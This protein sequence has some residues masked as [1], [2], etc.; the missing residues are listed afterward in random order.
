MDDLEYSEF[1][2]YPCRACGSIEYRY[3]GGGYNCREGHRNEE[4][5]DQV[6]DEDDY[7]FGRR[8]QMMMRSTQLSQSKMTPQSARVTAKKFRKSSGKGEHDVNER[9]GITEARQS[10][11]FEEERSRFQRK[12][13]KKKHVILEASLQVLILQCETL[14]NEFPHLWKSPDQKKEFEE[15]A[16]RLF[17]AYANDLSFPYSHSDTLHPELSSLAPSFQPSKYFKRKGATASSGSQKSKMTTEEALRQLMNESSV[18][19]DD[20]DKELL[21]DDYDYGNESDLDDSDSESDGGTGSGSGIVMGGLLDTSE[22]LKTA[23]YDT[24]VKMRSTMFPA[25]R[26]KPLGNPFSYL[27]MTFL[28]YLALI[29]TGVPVLFNDLARAL[30]LGVLPGYRPDFQLTKDIVTVRFNIN[31]LRAFHTRNLPSVNQLYYESRSMMEM[32]ARQCR[33]PDWKLDESAG[34]ALLRRLIGEMALPREY[35]PYIKSH[36]TRSIGPLNFLIFKINPEE[37]PINSL[38]LTPCSLTAAAILFFL[39]LLYTLEDED[40]DGLTPVESILKSQGLPTQEELVSQWKS[41]IESTISLTEEPDDLPIKDP[42]EY[43]QLLDLANRMLVKTCILDNSSSIKGI[44]GEEKY[45]KARA[46]RSPSPSSLK[47]N[48]FS[49][50]DLS[51]AARPIPEINL[52]LENFKRYRTYPLNHLNPNALPTAHRLCLRLIQKLIGIRPV[53]LEKIIK[54]VFESQDDEGILEAGRVKSYR[55]KMGRKV[56]ERIESEVYSYY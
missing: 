55:K 44:F 42:D 22:P 52:P 35:F 8:S 24:H 3:Y 4:L 49:Y 18:I 28:T 48:I 53:D 19:L 5:R 9:Y 37:D 38:Y 33:V 6:A 17:Q 51:S 54:L 2:E 11:L 47:G 50:C 13:D 39:R 45:E 21:L 20:L 23:D 15:L 36:V 46:I 32:L 12:G 40:E 27:N 31:E 7:D 30:E 29:H 43:A 1:L 14:K 16:R 41:R 25:R 56:V 10:E 26:T 34:D